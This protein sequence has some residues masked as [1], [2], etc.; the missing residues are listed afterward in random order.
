MNIL[1]LGYGKMGQLIGQLAESRGHT[2]AA[3]IN[4]DNRAEL[5]TL[6][7]ATID[8][9]I[10]FSQPEA[11]VENIKWAVERGIP[12][13]SGTTG[14]LEQKAEIEQLTQAKNGAFFYASN[15]SIGVNIFFKVNEFLAKL[16]NETTGYKSSVEEIHHTAK[17]D[18]PSGTAITLAEGI[19]KNIHELNNWNLSEGVSENEQ[20]L[21]I[22]SKR[23]DP[24]PGTHIIRY[25][26]EIDDIEI[27]HTAHSRQGFALGAILVSE[28]IQGKKGV[29][30]MDDFLSF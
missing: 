14:W 11:A 25:S 15:Y 21:P 18:A 27:S 5:D 28:W 6:D 13:V 9:A 1:L 2:I 4:I 17:K 20:S 30:S 10:E 16:M 8:V 22:T 23:I 29:L 19:I 3:K 7:P 12:I 26:S 24:A